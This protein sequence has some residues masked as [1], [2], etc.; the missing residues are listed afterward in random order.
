[1]AKLNENGH[2]ILDPTPMAIPIGFK[3][4]ETL[5]EQ[6]KRMVRS[7]RLAQ[8]A[9][10]QGYETWEEADDFDVDDDFDPSS[11]YE[12]HFDTDIPLPKVT[13]RDKKRREFTEEIPK[14]KPAKNEQKSS[15]KKDAQAEIDSES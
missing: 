5:A 15:T 12:Q 3:R 8:E 10:A 2:E 6:I 13:H 14:Q 1:M 7:E 4:P 9:E 11:P